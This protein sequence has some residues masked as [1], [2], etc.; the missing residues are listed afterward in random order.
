M[1]KAGTPQNCAGSQVQFALPSATPFS[2]FDANCVG[3]HF[4][5]QD[6]ELKDQMGKDQGRRL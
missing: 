3:A 5:R 2:D 1:L 6:I 4:S